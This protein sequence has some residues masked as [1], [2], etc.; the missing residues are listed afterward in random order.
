M[1]LDPFFRGR[2]IA[3]GG[4]EDKANELVVLKRVVQEVGKTEFKVGIIT[5]ASEVPEQR[6]KDYHQVFSNLGA[7][8]I[9]I[10]N[11][12]ERVQANDR[13]LAKSIEDA[14]LIFLTGGDQ[15]R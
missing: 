5:T 4:N 15:L 7:L 8:K 11:I 1:A 9:E 6:G 12:Q 14:D 10:L 13:T 2:L 3:I